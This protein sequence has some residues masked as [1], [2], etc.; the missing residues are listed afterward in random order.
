M[1]SAWAILLAAMLALHVVSSAG[2]MP[3]VSGGRLTLM[4]CPDGEWAAPSMAMPMG[5]D[6]HGSKPAGHRPCPY[7]AAA[8]MPF[9]GAAPVSLLPVD[10]RAFALFA[11]ILLQSPAQQRHA[12]RPPST[13]PPLPA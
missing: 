13:G 7:A 8:A 1:R 5:G 4:L 9:A 3:D 10:L 6:N 12:A 11:P 2:Y